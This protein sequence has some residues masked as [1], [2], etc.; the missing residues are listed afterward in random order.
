MWKVCWS[1][2]YWFYKIEIDGGGEDNDIRKM[3]YVI[4]EVVIKKAFRYKKRKAAKVFYFNY[5]VYSLDSRIPFWVSYCFFS[6][7][8]S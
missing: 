7:S 3:I 2:S 1:M 8:F 4:F 5:F 6:P